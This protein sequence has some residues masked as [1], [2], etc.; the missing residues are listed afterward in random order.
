MSVKLWNF[1]SLCGVI[2]WSQSKVKKVSALHYSIDLNSIRK[3]T[4]K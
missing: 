1:K 2:L 3:Y 4:L